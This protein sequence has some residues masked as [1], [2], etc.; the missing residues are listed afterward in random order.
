MKNSVDDYLM[1]MLAKESINDFLFVFDTNIFYDLYNIS[2][3]TT[4]KFFL[5]LERLNVWMPYQVMKEFSTGY[6]NK[7]LGISKISTIERKIKKFIGLLSNIKDM[8]LD[9]P[10]NK[11]ACVNLN[12][13]EFNK[14]HNDFID[15]KISEELKRTLENAIP[16]TIEDPIHNKILDLFDNRV[17]RRFSVT[18]LKE[19]DSEF[20]YR[21]DNNIPP[22]ILDESKD[23][24][25]KGDLII[26]KQIIEYSKNNE[27]SVIFV[28]NERK[29][30]W[31]ENFDELVPN[32]ELINEFY[33]ETGNEIFFIS[34]DVFFDSISKNVNIELSNEAKQ[35]ITFLENDYNENFF[36]DSIFNVLNEHNKIAEFLSKNKYQ[37]NTSKLIN[38]QN[39]ILNAFLNNGSLDV[40]LKMSKQQKII[41]SSFFNIDVSKIINLTLKQLSTLNNVDSLK[42]L[43]EIA[44][45]Q[46]EVENLEFNKSHSISFSEIINQQNEALKMLNNVD[47]L[48]NLSEIA[49]VQNEVK[50]LEFNKSH[51][52]SFSEIMNQ[53]N[54]A[55]KML[56][57]VDSLKNL[58]EIAR[59][60]NEVKNLEFNKSHSISFSEIINQQ[61]KMFD[62]NK[63]HYSDYSKLSIEYKN[64]INSI[65][66]SMRELIRWRR[67][68]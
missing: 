39:E 61:R 16:D 49:R 67:F 35:E 63:I 65:T 25:D 3:E 27:N 7:R 1:D 48:K 24:N 50:N 20:R 57:N 56:N 21:V 33:D 54:E 43:S 62:F 45:V 9:I 2:E 68:R 8:D 58:S 15:S 36:I 51:S 4:D 55:L 42:N 46:N 38:K 30:D 6:R 66:P 59:A 29:K 23:S 28:T 53:Q 13:N 52:I 22:G 41:I 32:F 37:K 17:G 11:L 47:S 19:L 10:D 34:F 14:I 12:F 44:R 60:Q 64:F 18:E 26:W 40:I 5:I 31:W